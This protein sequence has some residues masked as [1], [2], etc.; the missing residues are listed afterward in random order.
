MQATTIESFGTTE[1]ERFEAAQVEY[2]SKIKTFARSAYKQLPGHSV[3]DVEQ[4]LLVVLWRC[5]QNYDPNKGATFNTL[6]QGSARNRIISL[7]RFAS[8]QKRFAEVIS[9]DT[10]ALAALVGAEPS[11][12]NLANVL[13]DRRLMELSAPS[14]E[15]AA[16]LRMYISERLKT[17]EKSGDGTRRIKRSSVTERSQS[18]KV[19]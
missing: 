2:K 4:E 1:T 6:F 5:V 13:G 18:R 10:T 9:L 7:V 8:S 19:S 16:I 11:E 17:E 15:D 3:E 12:T 14:A